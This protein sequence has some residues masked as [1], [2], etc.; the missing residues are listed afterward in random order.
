M[1]RHVACSSLVPFIGSKLG[2]VAQ[3]LHQ[4][5]AMWFP[6]ALSL[7][8][9]SF[10]ISI[11]FM[12]LSGLSVSYLILTFTGPQASPLRQ[13]YPW[14][15]QCTICSTGARFLWS[16]QGYVC[17]GLIANDPCSCH[18]PSTS[19]PLHMPSL[20]MGC[21]QSVSLPLSLLKPAWAPFSVKLPLTVLSEYHTVSN[22]ILSPSS[23]AILNH[24][25]VGEGNGNPLQRSCL[26][27]PRDGGAW[28]AAVY[29]ITQSWIWLKRLSSSWLLHRGSSQP[30]YTG[31]LRIEE[32]HVARVCTHPQWH[33]LMVPWS[34]CTFLTEQQAPATEATSTVTLP[35]T[36]YHPIRVCALEVWF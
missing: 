24:S 11:L 22:L 8:S 6:Q 30:S 20:C 18:V 31:V 33:T 14:F 19:G 5:A 2:T 35:V 1:S 7:P 16:V 13:S 21:P 23:F 29:G 36:L 10:L 17:Y 27:N 3:S 32:L 4:L 15:S 26:E 34:H 25:L 12:L 28:W 9:P